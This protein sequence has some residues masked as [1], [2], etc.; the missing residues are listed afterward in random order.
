MN[1]QE[2][3]ASLPYS[4][5]MLGEPR[6]LPPGGQKTHVAA[7]KDYAGV[8]WS[9]TLVNLGSQ[10]LVFELERLLPNGAFGVVAVFPAPAGWKPEGPWGSAYIDGAAFVAGFVGHPSTTDPASPNRPFARFRL[11]IPNLATPFPPGVDPRQ[12]SGAPTFNGTDDTGGEDVNYTQI[13]EIVRNELVAHYNDTRPQR[14]QDIMDK[15][16]DGTIQAIRMAL[17]YDATPSGTPALKDQ[18]W[19][20]MGERIYSAVKDALSSER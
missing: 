3:T 2:L 9:L 15:S 19:Q 10:G 13:T 8:E 14:R 1:D 4:M 20:K 11:V 6:L 5:Q 7:A 18:W 12:G 17:G 16:R